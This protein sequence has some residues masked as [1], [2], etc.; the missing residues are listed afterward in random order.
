MKI[1]VFGATGATGRQVV[2]QALAA[3]HEVVAVARRASRVTA[4]AGL[5]VLAGDVLDAESMRDSCAGANAVVSCLGPSS[6]LR[7]GT[8]MSVGTANMLAAAESA[9]V[10]RFV[11]QSGIGLS[12][13]TELSLGFRILLAALWRPVFGA[14]LADKAEGERLVRAS[15]ID[16]VIVRP[17]GLRDAPAVGHYLAAPR[18]PVTLSA[19]AY[20]D[21]AAC[22]L[23]AVAE[24]TW[25]RE[26][27]NVGPASMEHLL[28]TK[29]NANRPKDQLD[30]IAH[31][32]RVEPAPAFRR[33]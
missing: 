1:V 14:A 21:C 30:V 11:F 7:P 19:L 27:V 13:G 12:D 22:L 9:G 15:S 24:P 17:V 33:C 4:R 20:A 5:V 6:N 28:L 18:A 26:T 29:R 23:R 31:T 25:T 16:W 10:R 8:V 2:E 32:S 3:G